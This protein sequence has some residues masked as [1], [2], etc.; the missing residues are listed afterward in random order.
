M[1]GHDEPVSEQDLQQLDVLPPHGLEAALESVMRGA[2]QA[3]EPV[4]G[5][6]WLSP[7]VSSPMVIGVRVRDRA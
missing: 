6:A 2:E 7:L 3:A 1:D 4:V 5:G